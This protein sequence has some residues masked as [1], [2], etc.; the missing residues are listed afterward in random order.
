MSKLPHIAIISGCLCFLAFM[1]FITVAVS[2][3]NDKDTQIAIACVQSGGEWVRQWGSY[4]CVR[5]N[6]D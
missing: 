6:N 1:G 3:N 2:T 5:G 4:N